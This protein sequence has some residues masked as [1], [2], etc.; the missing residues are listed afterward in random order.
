MDRDRLEELEKVFHRARE[1]ASDARQKYLDQ[2][3]QDDRQ[4]R[5]DVDELLEH[6]END[7]GCLA[8]HAIFNVDRLVADG[9]SQDL[10]GGDQIGSYIITERIGEG[11]FGRVYLATRSAGFRQQVAIKILRDDWADSEIITQRFAAERQILS[12][13]NHE[14]IAR[15]L[16]GGSTTQGRPYFVMEHVDGIPITEFCDENQLNVRK[17]LELFM[18]VC[19]A[20]AHAHQFGF[21]HRDI[22]P[23]NILVTGDGIPKLIDFGIAK[24][25]DTPSDA[26]TLGLTRTGQLPFTPEYA[27]PEQVRGEPVGQTSDVYSLGVVLYELL[28]G[29]RPYSFGTRTPGEIERIVCH[30]VPALPST[31]VGRDAAAT[32]KNCD[33]STDKA[34]VQTTSRNRSV[35]PERLKRLLN[36]DLDN[37]TLMALRKEPAR[38]YQTA[39]QLSDDIASHI[40]SRPVAARR[41]SMGY[42]VGKYLKRNRMSILA[43]TMAM[44]TLAAFLVAGYSA[45]RRSLQLSE[46]RRNTYASDMNLAYQSWEWGN[47]ERVL[48]L[49][50]RQVPQDDE[51]DLRGFEW[52]Y[53]AHLCERNAAN[54]LVSGVA[55]TAL[56][57]GSKMFVAERNNRL[58]IV[59]F[60]DPKEPKQ[61]DLRSPSVPGSIRDIAFAPDGNQ[62]AIGYDL[63]IS[64]A[65]GVVELST[66]SVAK[67]TC[68][69]AVLHV[70]FSPDG[71]HGAFAGA[72][73]I[74]GVR[75]TNTQKIIWK[76]GWLH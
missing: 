60:T 39:Q 10:V 2:A 61:S 76:R 20:V 31:V 49:L 1:L 72:N 65:V 25:I 23:T 22:K 59:D 43:A 47:L 50:E 19:G 42:V 75:E 27:S 41:D 53:L 63:E 8:E 15:L 51:T 17:R 64:G 6:F 38:R 24:L 66:D 34:D 37:I 56:R 44:I 40:A 71:A 45:R 29:R 28:A 26:K 7:S 58:T 54:T 9:H 12:D 21:I 18:R 73:G 32:T 52:Y 14:N 4:L 36:G 55:A 62:L 74:A 5:N 35:E 67:I 16:D 13:L 68:D 11:G 70:C 3:C 30:D 33:R 57:P 46:N 69:S 48:V